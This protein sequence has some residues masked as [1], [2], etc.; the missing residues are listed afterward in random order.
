MPMPPNTP[1]TPERLA[2][3][4]ASLADG[5]YELDIRKSHLPILAREG[6]AIIMLPDERVLSIGPDVDTVQLKGFDI[7]S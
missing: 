6:G 2:E 4:F 5:V 7:G 1:M 3:F